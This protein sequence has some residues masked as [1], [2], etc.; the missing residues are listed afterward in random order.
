MALQNGFAGFL[1]HVFGAGAAGPDDAVRDAAAPARKAAATAPPIFGTADGERIVGGP[2][3]DRIRGQGG[4][5]RLIGKAGNDTL[6]GAADQDT[7]QGNGGDDRIV[8]AGG[9]DRLVGNGGNDNLIGGSGDD[10]IRGGGG[11]DTM[12]GGAGND[13]LKGGG[14]ND[15]VIGNGGDDRLK[16]GGGDDF[17]K[18]G[19][20]DDIIDGGKGADRMKGNGGADIFTFRARD[21]GGVDTIVDFG[22]DAD[23]IDLTDIAG[24]G[25]FGDLR[26]GSLDGR[27]TIA[28]DGGTIRL[29]NMT[30]AS[31]LTAGD[32]IFDPSN[33]TS[34][35]GGGTTSGNDRRTG[36][37]GSDVIP[38]GAGTDTLTG[39]GGAD[40]FDIRLVGGSIDS[41]VDIV[42]DFAYLLGDRIGIGNVLAG[43]DFVDLTEVVRAT[44]TA[45]DTLIAINRGGGF[46]D[47]LRLEGVS[48]TTAELAAYGFEAAARSS[49]GFVEMPYGFTNN[50]ATAADPDATQ[51][52]VFI[53]FADQTN[54]DG[55]PDD[56]DVTDGSDEFFADLDVFVRNAATGA[57]ARVSEDGA[58]RTLRARDGTGADSHSP[59]ISADG[60]FVA[61]AT[62]GVGSPRDTN[63]EGDIYLR[64]VLADNAPVLIS[65]RPDGSAGGG[66]AQ[67]N[68][69][70]D[71]ISV[72]DI[73]GDG[74]KVAF[75][76]SADLTDTGQ[77]DNNGAHDVYLRDLD[78]GTTT[79]VSA[80][81]A[82]PDI[83]GG[84]RTPYTDFGDILK[85]SE[86]GRYVAFLTA[87]RLSSSDSGNFLD[88]YLKDTV[89]GTLLHVTDDAPSGVTGF[90]MSADG[91][92]IAFST[93]SAIDADDTNGLGDVYVADIDLSRMRTDD[94]FRV[95][96]APGGF[97]IR[98]DV[99]ESPVISADGNRVAWF[100]GAE[101]IFEF[102][103]S[104]TTE[105]RDRVFITDLRTGEVTQTRG[106]VPDNAFADSEYGTFT[107]D[108]FV[109]RKE[110][111]A[112][113]GGSRDVSD[114]LAND[115]TMALPAGA[116]VP[117]SP[118]M[119]G[120][121]LFGT[122]N[123]RSDI[124]SAADT[125]LYRLGPSLGDIVIT[126]EGAD[127]GGGTL[128]RP[129]LNIHLGGFD[130]VPEFVSV[131]RGNGDDD[132]TFT[133][134]GVGTNPVFLEVG[135][136]GTST[137]SY[138]LSIDFL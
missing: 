124:G 85:I 136:D 105:L 28:L 8:G 133:L 95:S 59:A 107:D 49:A 72:V 20:G 27:L 111:P 6:V 88:V 76:T 83:A 96:E 19:G 71:S 1:E 138:H 45:G 33:G 35:G 50:N 113:P 120:P 51:D 9:D 15:R 89:T 34:G 21:L 36:G 43:I 130:G 55:A 47:A 98:D 87:S 109:Y 12:K 126:L 78:A 79:L 64:D 94:V 112:A 102:D 18:G 25:S 134:F 63:D 30:D 92:R 108:G 125:D 54:L 37:P 110:V 29:A 131:P 24:I 48:F 3:D 32:F 81:A 123:L 84:V 58:G 10:V 116:D 14:G 122:S 44:P 16:G 114:T 103:P 117:G 73:S 119:G 2:D 66:V 82:S 38:T 42:T 57:I 137:G 90:D 7:L 115:G 99:S 121:L 118:V 13:N 52:G 100:S 127:N 74:R 129:T 77:T 104:G 53:A 41:A 61:F 5:D 11:D 93:T 67:P 135:G 69:A 17:L 31:A 75:V 23:R 80:A 60:R 97:E 128:E 106:D 40:V 68:F 65:V 46:V 86:D 26:F 132:H 4:N 62:D 39:N 70:A 22:R 56:V 91:S 101:D